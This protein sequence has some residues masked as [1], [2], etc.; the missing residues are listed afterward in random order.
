MGIKKTELVFQT[1]QEGTPLA[2]S[3]GET[4]SGAVVLTID[5][6]KPHKLTS[7]VVK[8]RGRAETD[9]KTGS[10]DDE[11]RHRDTEE[12]LRLDL[13]VLGNAGGQ[14]TALPPGR[15]QFPFQFS[16][17]PRLAYSLKH[18]DGKIRYECSARAR[19]DSF[20]SFDGRACVPFE[21]LARRDLSAEPQLAQPLTVSR[22]ARFSL[23]GRDPGPFRLYLTRQGFTAGEVI[24]ISLEGPGEA[25]QALA[26][27]DGTVQLKT[28]VVFR[29]GVSTRQKKWVAAAVRPGSSPDAWRHIRLT[30]PAGEV[31]LDDSSG[32]TI[33]SV[34]HYVKVRDVHLPVVLGTTPLRPS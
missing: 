4:M 15:H 3:P 26:K 19:S 12:L 29:A 23:L 22:E 31:T 8:V 1:R 33:I 6:S 24:D 25:F 2:F 18:M 13:T 11:S 20:W 5:G 21:V 9:W 17:P 28:R 7:V 32:C 34:T 14:P 27:A 30:V 10:G 16:L